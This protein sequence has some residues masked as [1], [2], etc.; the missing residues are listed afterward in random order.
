L[1]IDAHIGI[2]GDPWLENP[3]DPALVKK[4]LFFDDNISNQRLH[5]VKLWALLLL[6]LDGA[7]RCAYLSSSSFSGNG[8]SFFMKGKSFQGIS[9]ELPGRPSPPPSR[10]EG[11]MK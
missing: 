1:D 6:N 3:A 4:F 11:E 7:A 8:K 2:A 9:E 5:P 10:R